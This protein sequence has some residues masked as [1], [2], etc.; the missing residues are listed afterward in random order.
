MTVASM[1]SS[2]TTEFLEV[3]SALLGGIGTGI[4]ALFGTL[5]YD[6]TTGLTALGTWMIIFMGFSFALTIFYALFKKVA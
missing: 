1:G 6:S 2:I 4:S 3:V 5:I